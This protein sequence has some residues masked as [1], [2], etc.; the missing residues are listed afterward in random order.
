M[1]RFNLHIRRL[2]ED[3]ASDWHRCL[4]L[5]AACLVF[6]AL[7]DGALYLT[8]ARGASE[9]QA[10]SAIQAPAAPSTPV[11]LGAAA[12]EKAPRTVSPAAQRDPSL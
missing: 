7:V 2:G 1:R 3:P 11:R 10:V 12:A 8:L 9:L 6:A 5:F 4:A